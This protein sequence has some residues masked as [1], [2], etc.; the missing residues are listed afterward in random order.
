MGAL[1]RRGSDGAPPDRR[2]RF[3]SFAI[4]R[5][6]RGSSLQQKA[7]LRRHLRKAGVPFLEV[8]GRVFTT[9]GALTARLVGRAKPRKEPNWEPL[10]RRAPGPKNRG[11]ARDENLPGKMSDPHRELRPSEPIDLPRWLPSRPARYRRLER[12][13]HGDCRFCA[14]VAM[15]HRA[16][17]PAR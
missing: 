2:G 6:F 5:S 13:K 16:G 15:R 10:A 4:R 9:E 14:D 17:S 11:A 3:G 8:A 1:A 7:A 12:I